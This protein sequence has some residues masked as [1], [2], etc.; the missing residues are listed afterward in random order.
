[1]TIRQR[2][3]RFAET[4]RNLRELNTLTPRQLDDIGITRGDIAMYAR[5]RVN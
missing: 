5:G 3:A 2:L 4:R 1:M